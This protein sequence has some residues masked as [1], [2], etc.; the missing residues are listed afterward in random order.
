MRIAKVPS[1]N[2]GT[3]QLPIAEGP[4]ISA[5]IGA[6]PGDTNYFQFWFRDNGGP[7]GGVANLSNAVRVRWGL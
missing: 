2:D 5:L 3:A 6:Q 4:S 1:V 7:C